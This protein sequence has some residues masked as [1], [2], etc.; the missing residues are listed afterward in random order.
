MPAALSHRSIY[1]WT[2]TALARADRASSKSSKQR[3]SPRADSARAECISQFYAN[4]VS[5]PSIRA[6]LARGGNRVGLPRSRSIKREIYPEGGR[7]GFVAFRHRRLFIVRRADVS[8]CQPPPATLPDSTRRRKNWRNGRPTA[9]LVAHQPPPFV[10]HSRR[11]S[12]T[13]VL[14]G[15]SRASRKRLGMFTAGIRRRDF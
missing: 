8:Y 15:R 2:C 12:N 1:E 14:N 5:H 6:A 7:D 13:N 9:G 11:P 10:R 4:L 3:P